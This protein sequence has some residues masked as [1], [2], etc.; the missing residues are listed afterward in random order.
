MSVSKFSKVR[1]LRFFYARGRLSKELFEIVCSLKFVAKLKKKKFT[2]L[3]GDGMSKLKP[4]FPRW[5]GSIRLVWKQYCFGRTCWSVEMFQWF[6]VLDFV[7]ILSRIQISQMSWSRV[8]EDSKNN[9]NGDILNDLVKQLW[10]F[11]H[12][13]FNFSWELFNFELGLLTFL[14]MAVLWRDFLYNLNL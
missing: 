2:N 14:K 9:K 10:S 4:I 11:L 1:L 13:Q 6:A 5:Q 7:L 8:T 3:V 12:T